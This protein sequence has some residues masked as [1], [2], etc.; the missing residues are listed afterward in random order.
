MPYF[1]LQR[2]K[3]RIATVVI[4]AYSFRIHFLPK[5]FGQNIYLR[6][7]RPFP[8]LGHLYISYIIRTANVTLTLHVRS[9]MI[10]LCRLLRLYCYT[11]R[12]LKQIMLDLYTTPIFMDTISKEPVM[13]WN[14]F[15]ELHKVLS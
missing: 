6:N 5:K 4:I 13:L 10:Q 11:R 8:T 15:H 1:W 14:M 9:Y 12:W 3:F 2:N 7:Y